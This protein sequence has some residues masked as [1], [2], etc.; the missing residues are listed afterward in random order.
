LPL[1]DAQPVRRHALAACGLPL[2]GYALRLTSVGSPGLA[3]TRL[4]RVRLAEHRLPRRALRGRHHRWRDLCAGRLLRRRLVHPVLGTAAVGSCRSEAGYERQIFFMMARASL[5]GSWWVETRGFTTSTS[6]AWMLRLLTVAGSYTTRL[7]PAACADGGSVKLLLL[8]TT[9]KSK[10]LVPRWRSM[11]SRWS[12]TRKASVSPG[13]VATLQ[14]KTL[15]AGEALSASAIP[16][17]TRLGKILVY[18]LPGPTMIISAVRIASSASG[19]MVG[20]GWRKT[21]LMAVAT[22]RL[23]WLFA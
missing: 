17:T 12:L 14:T 11:A 22:S 8:L 13:C 10:M 15:M 9:T 2:A 3:G 18:R 20:S 5:S 19:L 21:R 4:H 1:A 6:T 23:P 7:M 16:S